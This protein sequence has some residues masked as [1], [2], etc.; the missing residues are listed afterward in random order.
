ML[1]AV[2]DP[3]VLVAAAITPNGISG[4]V[5]R[6]VLDRRCTMIVCPLLLAEL[7][8][9]LVRPKFRR[10]L[11]LEQAHVYVALVGRVGERHQD[12]VVTPGLTPDPDDD[13]LVALAQEARAG[14][15]ISGDPHLTKAVGLPCP[16][17]DPRTF[18]ERLA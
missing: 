2:L 14:Y 1:R 6:A 13:Y 11:T 3:G 15:L 7:E 12:P 8:E 9:V 16:V 5:L 18:L 17:L 4:E 10:Y